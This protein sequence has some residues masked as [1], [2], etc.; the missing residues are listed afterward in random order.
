MPLGDFEVCME[1][2]DELPLTNYKDARERMRWEMRNIPFWDGYVSAAV[3][4][5]H[6][7]DFEY[8]DWDEA[9]ETR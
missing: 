7:L 2:R 8:F 5:G 1:E 3:V 9:A 6:H 4:E